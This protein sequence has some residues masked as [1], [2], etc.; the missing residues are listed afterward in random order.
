M[1]FSES[2]LRT[3]V[4]P[5]LDSAALSHQLTMAGLEVEALAPVAPPFDSVRV[6]QI[7]SAAKH[8]DADRLQVCQVDVG[9]PE[10]LQ[11]VCGAANARVGLKTACAVV[12][13]KLPGF[14]I[15]RAKVRGVESLGMMCSAKELGM[16]SAADGI[17]EFPSDAPIGQPVRDYLDLDDQIFTL[18]LT[19]NRGDCLSIAGVAREVAAITGTVAALPVIEAVSATV[20]DVPQIT[21]EAVTACPRYCGRV[22]RGV[23]SAAVT[24]D[25]M[26]RRLARSG[27]RALHPVVDITNYVLLEMGQPMH[28]FDRDKL[29]GGLV[30]RLATAGESLELLN[31]QTIKPDAD[32]LLIADLSG[33]V[34][35]AGIMGGQ[36]SAVDATTVDVV[37]EAAH[38]T[39][40]AMA[41]RARRYALST[42]SS[43]RFE[44]G[45][46]AELPRQALERA[47][48]LVLEICGGAA[49]PVVEVGPGAIA[50][51]PIRF[52]PTR[53]RKV[54]GIALDDAGMAAHLAC[55][56]LETQVG[57]DVWQV[58]VP[59]H[60]FDLNIEV[61]LIEEI[62]RL[63]GYDRLPT[64]FPSGEARMRP[65]PE[66]R[67]GVA[68]IKAR[69]VAR[70][71]QEII[72]YSFIDPA[73]AALFSGDAPPITLLNP[74]AT[75]LSVMRASLLPGLV[76]TL[77]H[78]LNHGQERLRLF[79][80]GRCF[81][82]VEAD[83]QP[84]RVAGLLYG[85]AMPEQWG[86]VT[87]SADFFDLKAEVE[88]LAAPQGLDFRNEPHPALHPGQCACIYLGGRAVGW[89]GALHPRLVQTRNLVRPPLVFEL[90]LAALTE[91][92][93]PRYAGV[94]RLPAVRR[95][96]AVLVDEGVPVGRVLDTLR[97]ALPPAVTALDL[98]DVY[99]GKGLPDG[100]KSLAFKVLLQHTEKTFTDAEIDALIG[101]V[102]NQMAD[103]F[104]AVL[105]GGTS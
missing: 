68:S 55:L 98:F 15:K 81:T 53:A 24:P 47:T 105:R 58:Q 94:A 4:N 100:K 75:P 78:N 46:A 37:L 69:L 89:L 26:Q 101:Q 83:H 76:Q 97:A 62:A 54:L 65:A 85:A 73:D 17:L 45:V 64:V 72:T 67:R 52:R 80:V 3:W 13:A 102:L 48:Q 30:V 92:S 104:G 20:N 5:A 49:G 61:D 79:E 29:Q 84:Q 91:G 66:D 86:A 56:G 6:A 40:A 95:D 103:S 44:R 32:T 51:Q 87:R 38:F 25:W 60:R 90:D 18:K 74:I 36:G 14:E 2:W 39:P 9:G 27:V 19:P 70:G 12:G 77:R 63:E 71:W 59:A 23:N 42:D 96:L 93:L 34:A 28:A 31:G 35:L 57:Q 88:A 1:Q 43:H 41:G 11:I 22:V 33:P 10:P 16:E 50:R 7:L 8:P 21:L 99:R 82:G